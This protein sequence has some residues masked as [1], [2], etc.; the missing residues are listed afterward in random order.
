MKPFLLFLVLITFD[1]ASDVVEREYSANWQ[2][3]FV[4]LENGGGIRVVVAPDEGGELTGFSVFF[5][6]GWNELLYR[7]LDYSDK[8]GWRGKAP[9]LWPATGISMIEEGQKNTYK[10]GEKQ[11]EMPFHGFA[12]TQKWKIGP[13]SSSKKSASMTLRLTDTDETRR[14]Y[15]FAFELMVEYRLQ[16]DRLSMLYTVTADA[17]NDAD[18]P[19]SIGNHITFNAPL[20]EGSKAADLQFENSL[21]ELLDKDAN[22]AFAGAT[23]P[24][25]FQGRYSLS[26]LPTRGSVSLGGQQNPA[27]LTIFDPSG[28]K[29][30]LLHH[31]SSAPSQPVIQFNLWADTE[32]GFF[33]P[34]PWVGT[35][36]SLNTGMGL[37]S[38]EPGESWRW[39]ID[40]IPVL[41]TPVNNPDPTEMK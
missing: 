10:L 7:A 1:V 22:K 25:S 32:A 4:V 2:D 29:V 18:M 37:V 5:D 36:N 33:S 11:Y 15:P 8:P 27:E 34:E 26:D 20:I 35:Q 17:G 21:P 30:Q 40:I 23:K 39:R 9:L 16:A 3:R 14:Y 38:L 24:S 13:R 12:R 41:N 19:F 31:Y 6:G 28:L